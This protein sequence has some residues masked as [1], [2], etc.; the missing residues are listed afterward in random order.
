MKTDHNTLGKAAYLFYHLYW[1]GLLYGS[2][3]LSLFTRA[4]SPF[5][6]ELLSRA[7]SRSL[8]LGLVLVCN[9][10]GITAGFDRYRSYTTV[11]LTATSPFGLYLLLERLNDLPVYVWICGGIVVLV[12]LYLLV[13][14]FLTPI[15]R[16][17][18]SDALWD[19]MCK[20]LH[21]TRA[22]TNTFLCV[23]TLVAVLGNTFGLFSVKADP[24][25]RQPAGEEVPLPLSRYE[26]EFSELRQERWTQKTVEEKV[27]LLQL[28]SDF[29]SEYLGLSEK[30]LVVC[31]GLEITTAGA[32]SP[33]ENI[34]EINRDQILH[35]HVGECL[36]TLFHELYHAYQHDLVRVYDELSEQGQKLYFLRNAGIYKY[37]FEHYVSGGSGDGFLEYYAQ[38][39]EQSARQYARERVTYYA[40]HLDLDWRVR[41][42]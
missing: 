11:L 10:V 29:E 16:K 31:K 42:D 26:T 39:V 8:L 23:L 36:D 13:M 20:M 30:P 2:F 17:R 7:D 34:V 40:D 21:T 32:F 1:G 3:S 19:R 6:G 18:V 9:M 25:A 4:Y 35:D 22:L 27:E 14:M 41:T 24:K 12:A 33:T 15:R 28:V 5:S 37:E 38:S